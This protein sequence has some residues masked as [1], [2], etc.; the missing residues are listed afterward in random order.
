MKPEA[1]LSHPPKVLAQS[2]RE[3]HFEQ[4]YV[5]CRNVLKDTWLERM[6]NAYER[7]TERSR[8]L[9][10]SN[11]WLSLAP[12]H[13]AE[14]PCVYRIERLPDQ[15]PEFWAVA[16]ESRLADLAS[17]VLGPDVIYRDSVINVKPP[18]E[19]GAVT[20]HQDFPFYPHT[21]VGTIQVLTALCDVSEDQGPLTVI[22]GTH[23]GRIFEH[24]DER[25][26][27]S[28][29]IG[30]RDLEDLDLASAVELPC[31]AG[32][33]VPPAPGDRTRLE[34]EHFE[35]AATPSDPWNERCRLALLHRY[36][37]GQLAHRRHPA[38]P[39]SALCPARRVGDPPPSRLVRRV[40]VDLRAPAGELIRRPAKASARPGERRSPT[41]TEV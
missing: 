32:D 26:S 5:L 9:S 36:R 37:M 23:R 14:T 29:E 27:W 34:A 22:P 24:Y 17:D 18:G 13:N 10:R 4:G 35:A 40:H 28:G 2:D 33:A 38:R 25:G 11:R 1:V 8:A 6:R 41:L 20:W 21:N 19:R 7:A 15:D 3:R 31:A 12:E 16:T 39:G 30:P